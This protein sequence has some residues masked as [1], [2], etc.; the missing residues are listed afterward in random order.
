MATTIQNLT[1]HTV[2]IFAG[3][4]PKHFEPTGTVA[5]V[6]YKRDTSWV[7]GVPLVA[8]VS[9]TVIDLPAPQEN[10][11]YIVSGMVFEAVPTR[12]DLLAPVQPVRNEGGRVIGCK[13]LR[14]RA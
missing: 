5:R 13:M 12:N 2:T 4:A 7:A 10:V 11:Y 6:H 8:D 1:P 9:H 14:V 3:D